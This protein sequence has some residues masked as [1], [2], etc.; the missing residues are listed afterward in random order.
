L[1][2]FLGGKL[3]PAQVKMGLSLVI[4]L[5]IYP[6]VLNEASLTQLFSAPKGNE[7]PLAARMVG[8]ITKEVFIGFIL[9][10][11]ILMIWYAAEMIGRFVDTARGSAM[12][13]TLVPEMG[14]QAS[15]LGS[16]YYQLLI[17]IF[18]LLDGHLIFLNYFIQSYIY[19]P[20]ASVPRI[21]AGLWPLFEMI[22]RITAQLFVA[23]IT[24]SAPV[25]LAIFVTDVC[26]GLFNKVAPQINVMFLMM[27][28]KAML[29]ILICMVSLFM[30]VEESQKLMTITLNQV[31]MAIRY[32]SPF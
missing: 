24:L 7:F 6:F 15:T 30:F 20:L 8:L 18:L 29:G 31:W 22:M 19:I 13:A 14:T 3:V 32:L 26:M 4:G 21:D 25:M 28:F 9:G 11:I 27:P 16:L 5:L 12:G 23:A 10:Y 17:V 2:P 1:A